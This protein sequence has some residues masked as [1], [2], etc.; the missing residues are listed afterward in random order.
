[1]R[2][3]SFK[4]IHFLLLSLWLLAVPA[5]SG[6]AFASTLTAS[7]SSLGIPYNSKVTYSNDAAWA[8]DLGCDSGPS[9]LEVSSCQYDG[10]AK[11]HLAVDLTSYDVVTGAW[12]SEDPVGVTQA[13]LRR[14]MGLN[15]WLYAD[16]NPTRYSDKRGTDPDDMSP[17]WKQLGDELSA[18]WE[19]VFGGHARVTPQ[20]NQVTYEGPRGGV[21]GAVGGLARAGT[22]RTLSVEERPSEASLNG[23][24]IGASMVPVLD[25][26]ARLATGKTV[27]GATAS[28]LA[29]GVQLALDV[30]TRSNSQGFQPFNRSYAAGR[31]SMTAPMAT[32]RNG[33]P[34]SRWVASSCSTVFF[35]Y[36]GASSRTRFTGQLGKRHS[37]SRR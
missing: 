3:V 30:C 18:G 12:L 5:R 33:L 21:G 27:T 11:I 37:K 13:R 36:A 31:W 6:L 25:P 26:V 23:M 10:P 9:P 35:Q 17:M 34:A 15:P 4:Q 28:R 19:S 29:A 16:A 22:L 1:M 8:P 2:A 24:E 32:C 14:P 7:G 20:S